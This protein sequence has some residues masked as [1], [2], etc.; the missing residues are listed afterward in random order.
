MNLAQQ[1]ATADTAVLLIG[2]T[3]T[4]KELIAR[5][6]HRLSGRRGALI[7]VNCA[8]LHRDLAEG[9][10][11]G[12]RKGAYTGAITDENGLVASA[13]HGTLFLDEL[14]SLPMEIQGKLLRVLETKEVRRVGDVDKRA[15][16][17]RL[18]SASQERI[19][20]RVGQGRFRSDLLHRV[21]G[22]VIELPPL[23]Q[24]VEEVLPLARFF[25]EQAGA[26]L[27]SDAEPL[28]L[29]YPWPGNVRELKTTI[30][31]AAIMADSTRLLSRQLV[32]LAMELGDTG[33][34]LADMSVDPPSAAEAR[35]RLVGLCLAAGWN[36]EQV[37][38]TLGVGR[39][40]IYRRLRA[41]GVPVAVLR[42]HHRRGVN[43][44]AVGEPSDQSV[45]PVDS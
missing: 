14:C 29:G 4:G 1:F 44:G 33:D 43:G 45:E 13:D 41:A 32:I 9:E 6:I 2:A 35:A 19:H 27:A 42:L 8:A 20:H 34:I 24:R 7:D 3:G 36:I 5:E 10:L 21:A 37:A 30:E 39:A 12:H 28:L 15:I 25:A 23:I 40:T 22:V 26:R 38:K 18:I 16:D 31:R 17:F 11:F